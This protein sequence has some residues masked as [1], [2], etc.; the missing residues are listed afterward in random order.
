MRRTLRFLGNVFM[1]YGV[2]TLIINIFC[3]LFGKGAQ[4]Y[5][6]MFSLGSEGIPV[7]TSAEFL[8]TVASVVALRY[9]FMTETLIK[10]MSVTVRMI[11]MFISAFAV[12]CAYIVLFG[13]FPVDMPSTWIMF[14][15]CFAVSCT[16]SSIISNQSEKQENRR[17]EEALKKY[18]E[19]QE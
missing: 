7:K 16:V 1:I 17:L 3:I 18:K 14:I 5:S 9:I 2:T 8:L 4:G 10:D 13:W 12:T 19:E 15:I 6:M 11:L